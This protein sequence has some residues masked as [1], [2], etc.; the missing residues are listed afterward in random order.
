MKNT[1][2]KTELD[3]SRAAATLAALY[4]GAI[5]DSTRPP[6]LAELAKQAKWTVLDQLSAAPES[7]AEALEQ[8]IARADRWIR[9]VL[10]SDPELTAKWRHLCCSQT[11]QDIAPSR[12]AEEAARDR[13]VNRAIQQRV[14]E[15]DALDLSRQLD[16]HQN[17]IMA[18][19]RRNGHTIRRHEQKGHHNRETGGSRYRRSSV[20]P[21]HLN[22]E[23]SKAER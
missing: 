3:Y 5:R 12:Q 6:W 10:R 17:I 15:T 7:S 8:I 22:Q 1:T 19:A 23:P 4:L 21:V 13:V 9:D 20:I 18:A 2:Q 16:A 11:A 14:R